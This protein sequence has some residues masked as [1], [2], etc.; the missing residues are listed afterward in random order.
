[1]SIHT[2][3]NKPA[4]KPDAQSKRS[5]QDPQTPA[6]FR[7][8]RAEVED[9]LFSQRHSPCR[10]EKLTLHNHY[11]LPTFL[12]EKQILLDSSGK[13]TRYPLI[14]PPP[15]NP[16]PSTLPPTPPSKLHNASNS[17]YRAANLGPK[18]QLSKRF[19]CLSKAGL[20]TTSS[21]RKIRA[22]MGR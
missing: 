12:F 15:P 22:S 1:M 11:N 3:R 6:L 19:T 16:N 17:G 18:L 14:S 7:S 9:E 5:N 2:P 21:A 13:H 10:T 20:M 4:K 8:G